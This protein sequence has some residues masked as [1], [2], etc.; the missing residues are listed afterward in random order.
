MLIQL[1][2]SFLKDLCQVLSCLVEKAKKLTAK[3]THAYQVEIIAKAHGN[4][5]FIFTFMLDDVKF[6][7]N[8]YQSDVL[9]HFEKENGNDEDNHLKNSS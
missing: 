1:F 4:R 3:E 8:S 5:T 7:K 2:F 6:F 9:G